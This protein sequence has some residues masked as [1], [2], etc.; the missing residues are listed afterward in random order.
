[1]SPGATQQNAGTLYQ[2]VDILGTGVSQGSMVW[3]FFKLV[4][5]QFVPQV[6]LILSVDIFPLKL[7]K[8]SGEYVDMSILLKSAK[9]LVTD[10]HLN[11]DMA[12]KGGQLTLLQHKQTPNTHIHVW[13]LAFYDL[14]GYNA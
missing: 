6:C 13:T 4:K 12:V 14:Y 5:R 8:K 7:K 2:D 9:D 3:V 1:V 11:G 10:S